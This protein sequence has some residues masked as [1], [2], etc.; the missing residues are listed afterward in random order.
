[1][2]ASIADSPTDGFAPALME[3]I[4]AYSDGVLRDDVAILVVETTGVHP[5]REHR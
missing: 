5:A 4:V 1:M 2:V 3:S